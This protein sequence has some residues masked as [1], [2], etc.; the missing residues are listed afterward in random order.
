MIYDNYHISKNPYAYT[1]Y[2]Y[3]LINK[4]YRSCLVVFEYYKCGVFMDFDL[5]VLSCKLYP[6]GDVDIQRLCCTYSRTS[7]KGACNRLSNVS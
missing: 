3:P 1:S 2:E 6:L 4:V 5:E 7:V